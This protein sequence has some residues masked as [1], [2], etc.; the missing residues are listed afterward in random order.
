MTQPRST[1]VCLD[2]TP[3]YHVVSR[4]VRRAFLCG[5]DSHSGRTFEHRRGGFVD[6][7]R[8]P[9]GA[10]TSTTPPPCFSLAG[11]PFS[12]TIGCIPLE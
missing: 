11:R 3:W 10:N 1:R 7:L 4:C 12:A 9:A 2:A 5:F 8:R 6:W